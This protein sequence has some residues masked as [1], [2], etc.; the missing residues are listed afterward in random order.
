MIQSEVHKRQKSKNLAMLIGLVAFI[1]LVFAV[2]I[3]R[4]S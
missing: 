1:A 3:L 4:M 2:T